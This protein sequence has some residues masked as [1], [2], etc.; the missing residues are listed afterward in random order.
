MFILGLNA[1]HGDASACLLRDGVIVAAAEEERF[2]RIKHWA[3]FPSEA[4][5]YCL[6]EAGI[7]LGDVAHVAVNSDPKANILRRVGYVVKQRPELRLIVDRLRNQSKRSSVEDE[8]ASACPGQ[9]FKGTVH[10][11]EHHLSHLASCFLVSPFREAVTVSVDGFGDFASAAWGT[12]R[13][14][15][16]EI[17][18]RVWFPHSLGIF[19]Q[20]LTQFIGFP[21]YGD[22][23]KVMGLAPYGEPKHMDAMRKIVRLQNDGSFALD[24]SYFR[25]HR[26]KIAY[27]WESGSPHVGTLFGPALEELM[28]PARDKDAPLEQRHRDI[29]RSVQAMYEEAFFHLLTTLHRKYGLDSLTL[30]GGCAMN[31]VAN[32]KIKRLSP[33]K[34]VYIQSAAG[35]AGGA[36]GA[37]IQVWHQRGANLST[38]T[39]P[40]T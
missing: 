18:G 20:A 31:S 14:S 29:A 4:I 36:I 9:P 3:G 23:Y 8:L 33:F 32:G 10:R 27:E 37:A 17:D 25:H 26:E 16:I 7:G 12:G 11:I 19:Y 38:T 22:E 39:A 13:G 6:G 35:D 21:Y 24:L 15:T 40:S 2:R 1:Y 30:A 5:R 28:G 34:R